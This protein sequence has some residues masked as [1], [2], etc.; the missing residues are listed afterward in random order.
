MDC[1]AFEEKTEEIVLGL[2]APPEQHAADEHAH[3]CASCRRAAEETQATILGLGLAV[4]QLQPPARLKRRV[5]AAIAAPH[6][7]S[8]GRDDAATTPQQPAAPR[9][10]PPATRWG[11]PLAAAAAVIVA[12][13]SL[14]WSVALQQQVTAQQAELARL[15]AE[16]PAAVGVAASANAVARPLAGT[17]VAPTAQGK[18]LLDEEGNGVIFVSDMPQP[19]AGMAYQVWLVGNGER[20]SAGLFKVDGY[21]RGY[22]VFDCPEPG[23]RYSAVGI[24]TE[25]EGGSPG[26]TTP[27]VIGGEL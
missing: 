25:P 22:L 16:V 4:P 3:L 5:M 11:W 6:A 20:R 9:S 23:E 10:N 1:L 14:A 27:R 7:G 13:G 21:G 12:L 18:I 24:T 17:D 2:L 19:A 15:R 8:P 26:P